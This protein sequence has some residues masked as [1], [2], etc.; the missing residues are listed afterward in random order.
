MSQGSA[1]A[2]HAPEYHHDD[3]VQLAGL[4]RL[5][6]A[7][8]ALEF[9]GAG[10][11]DLISDERLTMLGQCLRWAAMFSPW[12]RIQKLKLIEHMAVHYDRKEP[13]TPMDYRR[14]KELV[15]AVADIA[16]ELDAADAVGAICG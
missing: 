15:E 11:V 6:S 1:T 14:A 13:V 10:A 7:H 5:S 2:S 12:D 8:E 4:L 16:D 9:D 3:L